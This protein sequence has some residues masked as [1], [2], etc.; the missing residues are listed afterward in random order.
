[1]EHPL[2][3]R[4]TIGAATGYANGVS[5]PG[6]DTARVK[7]SQAALYGS[8]RLGG[9]AYVGGMASAETS[10]VELSR[11]AITGSSTFDLTGATRSQRYTATAEAGVNV[12]IGRGLTLTPR[13]Q[14][15]YSRYQLDGF[16]ENGGEVALQMDDLRLQKFEARVGAK[17][18]GSVD[19]GDGWSF[20]PQIQADYV[21]LLSGANDGLAVRFANAPDSRFLLPLGASGSYGEVRGGLRVSK[22]QLDF[23]AGLQANIGNT[24]MTDNRANA[25]FTLRL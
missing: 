23:G 13:A 22:G 1:M 17:L 9:G 5:T 20:T 19:I 25:E 14:L 12:G 4:L 2:T 10:S 8:Y 18:A 11:T 7:T 16:R 3:S 24:L 6:S 15:G 21:H